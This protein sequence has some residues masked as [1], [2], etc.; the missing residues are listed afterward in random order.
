MGERGKRRCVVLTDSN[1]RGV[2]SDTIKIHISVEEERWEIQ[3]VQGRG[4]GRAEEGGGGG[5]K[6]EEEVRGADRL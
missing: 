4:H 5:G 1:G 3:V 2:T 6:G